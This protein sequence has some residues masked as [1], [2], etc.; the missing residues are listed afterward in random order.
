MMP[1][2]SILFVLAFYSLLNAFQLNK[3]S[4]RFLFIVSFLILF[5]FSAFRYDVGMDYLSY[6]E[7][8]TDSSDGLNPKISE[9]GFELFFYALNKLGISYAV[10]VFLLSFLTI[11]LAF[12][13]IKKYSPYVA[14]SLLIFYCLGQFYFNTFNT[15]RQVVV[16]YA[17]YLLLDYVIKKCFLKYVFS[18]LLLSICFHLTALILLPLY[19][20]LRNK[21][22][23][24]IK[25]LTITVISFSLLGIIK[26]IEISPYAVY[27]NFEQFSKEMSP[28]MY[29]LLLI[30]AILFFI[31]LFL[32]NE[33]KS[34]VMLFNINSLLLSVLILSI[35]VSGTPLIIVMGRI[36]YYF[37]PVILVLIPIVISKMKIK[38]NKCIF[39]IC[40]GI[41]FS[42]LCVTSIWQNGKENNLIPYMTIFS[43]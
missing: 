34:E 14:F 27:L 31:D 42:A 16:I 39:I 1:Y 22:S 4:E 18:I 2:L 25:L 8:F 5:L 12:C 15:M 10:A 21:Y 37:S 30:S 38:S 28:T 19:F 13:Y 36:S 6:Q 7:W 26:L 3:K 29:M 20:F 9:I 41:L 32:K 24:W 35:L 33:S 23:A 11:T 40:I 17:F 43:R